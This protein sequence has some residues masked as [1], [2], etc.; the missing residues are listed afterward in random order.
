MSGDFEVRVLYVDFRALCEYG[1]LRETL[2]D[3]D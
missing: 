1:K 3:F 2:D